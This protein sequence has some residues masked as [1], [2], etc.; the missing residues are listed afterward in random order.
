MDEHTPDAGW[1]ALKQALRRQALV[2]GFDVAAF[3]P[4]LPPPHADHLKQWLQ[5]Q[6]HGEMHWMAR[7]PERRQDPRHG[8]PELGV[9]LVLGVNYCP[10]DDPLAPGQDASR[11]WISA[12]AR[13]QDYH[14]TLKRRLKG[15]AAWLEQ[16]LD[17]S[18][19]G[20]LCVD[21]A[22]LLEKPLAAAAGVGWQGKNSLL[23]SPRFG[24]WLFLAEYLLPL[25]LP[26]DVPLPD[27]CGS[28]RRCLAACPTDALAVPYQLNARRC[29]AYLTI[30]HAGPLPMADRIAMGNRVYG[31][32]NCL[33]VCPWNRFA[34][35]TRET[36]FMPRPLLISPP[37]LDCVMLE[38]E[39]FRSRMAG[40]PIQRMGVVRFLRNVAVAL[41]NWGAP[42]ALPALAR[43]LQ[44]GAPLVRGH[45]AWGIG[46]LLRQQT[47]EPF[48]A[49]PDQLL[50]QQLEQEGEPWVREEIMLARQRAV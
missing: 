45:A 30:E 7:Q 43:L 26:A 28:C 40:S 33:A 17:R 14:E 18:I 8:L 49:T 35:P 31:C 34:P 46:R 42:E 11:G 19:G 29:L 48:G 27:R 23:V 9:V 10:A 6:A 3:A 32:D 47:G 21:T 20:R 41:G 39:S 37:L 12:Y 5:T 15:L 50:G 24:C 4:P 22:P 1:S 44:H 36:D 16:R 2:A 13:N 25:P 38:A